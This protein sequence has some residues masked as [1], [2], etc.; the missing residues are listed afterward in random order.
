MDGDVD[1]AEISLQV[2]PNTA[3]ILD[4][5]RHSALHFTCIHATKS[6]HYPEKQM[7][8]LLLRQST[9]MTAADDDRNLAIFS[10]VSLAVVAQGC[11]AWFLPLLRKESS[12]MGAGSSRGFKVTHT[13]SKVYVHFIFQ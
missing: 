10:T 8:G 3:D 12:K 1:R 7:I 5:W 4:R 2:T 11:I 6:R 13:Q 9:D